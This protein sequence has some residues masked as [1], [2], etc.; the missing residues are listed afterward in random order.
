MEEGFIAK[1]FII[2]KYLLAHMYCSL[3]CQD[4][5]AVVTPVSIASPNQ[6]VV[7]NFVVERRAGLDVSIF[8][9]WQS[10]DSKRAE[11]RELWRG[12][13]NQ[14]GISLPVH[15]RVLKGSEVFF[16]DVVVTTGVNA[17]RSLKYGGQQKAVG[18]RPVRSLLLDSGSY[19][20]E[21]STVN[22]VEAFN[23][24]ECYFEFYAYD[25]R[26]LD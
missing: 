5:V 25:I 26:E 6:Q 24:E 19:S 21:V 20:V 17:G 9:V 23:G 14:R 12:R 22:V 2:A 8:F 15:M 11:Q 3:V 10:G 1:G 13:Y 7:A 18:V 16:D 4:P